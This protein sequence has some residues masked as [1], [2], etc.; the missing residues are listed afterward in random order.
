[1]HGSAH[2]EP[3]NLKSVGQVHYF[4][5]C[6]QAVR[7]LAWAEVA[8]VDLGEVMGVGM[9]LLLHLPLKHAS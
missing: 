1:M 6:P 5:D 2:N 3:G 9:S 8:A 4:P 7:P